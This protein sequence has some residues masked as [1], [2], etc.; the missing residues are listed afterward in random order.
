MERFRTESEKVRYMEIKAMCV[1]SKGSFGTTYS[2]ADAIKRGFLSTQSFA[3]KI[4]A[5]GFTGC[6]M[7]HQNAGDGR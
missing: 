3:T 1:C 5:F 2:S 4:P 6:E 7:N